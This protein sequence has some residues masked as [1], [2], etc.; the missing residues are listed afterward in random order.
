MDPFSD[1]LP[2]LKSFSTIADEKIEPKDPQSLFLLE[3]ALRDLAFGS[4]MRQQ[5]AAHE[6]RAIAS[7]PS[8]QSFA[9]DPFY[10]QLAGNQHWQLR[11]GLYRHSSEYIYTIPMHLLVAVIGPGDLQAVHYRMPPNIINHTFDPNARLQAGTR[12]SYKPG[13]IAIVDGRYDIFDV[14]IDRPI[15]ALKLTSGIHQSLQWAFHRESLLATQAIAAD[16]IDSE[17]VSMA[18][19]LGAMRHH[20]STAT[21]TELANHPKH[22][23][24]WAAIQALGQIN[25]EVAIEKLKEA[26]SDKHSHIRRAAIAGLQKLTKARDEHAS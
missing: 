22:F 7:D 15:V 23:V 1:H 20:S 19:A 6:L 17:L 13:D 5:L 16:P 9:W 18:Q 8:Y 25:P 21:L 12:R 3:S 14:R 26:T 11:V 10:I 2:A 4:D 24:R